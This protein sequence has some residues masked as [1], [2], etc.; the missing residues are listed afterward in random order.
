VSIGTLNEGPLHQAIKSLYCG[1][2]AREEVAV[3]DYVADVR[4][5]DD[6]IYEIQ[7]AGFSALKTKLAS[8][9]DQHR[10]VLVHPVATVRYIVK[11]S[12]EPD[13]PPTR[14]R[15]PKRGSVAHV[16]DEL[17]SIPTLLNHPNFELEVILIEVEELRRFDPKK[18]RRRNG[19]RVV[20]RSLQ[21]VLGRERFSCA[22][23]LFR[24]VPGALPE[25]FTTK[26]LAQAMGQSRS[27]AQKL[28][29]CLR[30]AGEISICGKQ[31][32][33][34]CYRLSAESVAG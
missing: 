12:E 26:E 18:V 22:G 14:R 31:G 34:L 15:S 16:L 11:L 32:N 25:E 1:D 33:A 13:L 20:H 9:V 5:A 27:L 24:M 10:V 23:D 30:E 7:T 21:E 29:Y 8:L 19:W 3:G 2:G 28:A 4:G 6:I 17:V